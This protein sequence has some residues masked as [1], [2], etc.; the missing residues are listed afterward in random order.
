[1]NL[2]RIRWLIRALGG[3]RQCFR[4]ICSWKN[5]F[6]WNFHVNVEF[7]YIWSSLIRLVYGPVPKR[8][9]FDQKSTRIQTKTTWKHTKMCRIRHVFRE[10]AVSREGNVFAKTVENVPLPLW[11]RGTTFWAWFSH[12]LLQKFQEK[13]KKSQDPH[14][15]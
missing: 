15:K 10:F 12:V 13:H 7:Q 11:R 9:F 5:I 3:V 6:A 4:V 14:K 8:W 1:M 2:D